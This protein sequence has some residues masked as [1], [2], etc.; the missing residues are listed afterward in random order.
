MRVEL[1]SPGA[2]TRGTSRT[3]PRA[4]LL[5]FLIL[6]AGIMAAGWL[7]STQTKKDAELTAQQNLAA[8]ADLKVGQIVSWRHERLGD[9][10]L[11]SG[12]PLIVSRLAAFL[13]NHRREMGART[14]SPGWPRCAAATLTRASRCW[15]RKAKC[16]SRSDSPKLTLIR[17]TGPMWPPWPGRGNHCCRIF[18]GRR[19]RAVFSWTSAL[20]CC[21][22]K[23]P[24]ALRTASA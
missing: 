11:I 22:Q 18:I 19:K 21:G 9:A 24:R 17:R 6:A 5:T 4:L 3:I 10:A 13:E 23:T 15:M 12:N 8:I 7:F 2:T 1:T 14:F 20:R 16:A